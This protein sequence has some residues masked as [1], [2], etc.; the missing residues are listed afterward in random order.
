MSLRTSYTSDDIGQ[1]S[2]DG[3]SFRA[4]KQMRW[5]KVRLAYHSLRI[6]MLSFVHAVVDLLVVPLNES[7]VLSMAFCSNCSSW[8][9]ATA[10]LLDAAV[11][12]VD[13][14]VSSVGVGIASE[15]VRRRG[16]RDT[17]WEICMI[18]MSKTIDFTQER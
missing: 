3:F 9:E 18:G 17:R 16:K 13:V 1:S 4:G 7:S 2:E 8:S 11:G 6:E 14:E 10:V 12:R 5:G 15:V